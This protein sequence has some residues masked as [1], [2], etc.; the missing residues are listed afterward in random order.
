MGDPPLE[1]GAAAQT[2]LDDEGATDAARAELE[3]LVSDHEGW[4]RRCINLIASE[5]QISPAVRAQLATDLVGRYG[6]YLGRDAEHRKYFGTPYVLRIE[7]QVNDL[8]CELFGAR[9]AELRP[10]SGHVA[11]AAVLLGLCRPGDTVLEVGGDGGGHRMAAKLA[12]GTLIDLDVRFLPFDTHR[13][14]VDVAAS[15]AL[16]RE[17]R[18][19][20]VI[21]GSSTFLFPHP[22]ADL[23]DAVHSEGGLLVYDASHVMGLIA[24]GRFQQPLAEGADLIYGS[25]HK[26]LPGPQGGLI[27][28]DDERH[29]EAIT[30]ATY[31]AL[32]TNHHLARL[33]ALGIALLEVVGWG[34]AY[35]DAIIANA[36]RLAAELAGRGLPVAGAHDGYSRSHTILVGTGGHGGAEE[37]GALLEAAGMIVT[38]ARLPAHLGRVGVRLG[39]QEITRLGATEADMVELADLLFAAIARRAGP[40]ELAPRVRAWA[41]E[42]LGACRYTWGTA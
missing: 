34:H 24:A 5:N 4:R 8:A 40:D 28:A 3:G 18:P 19:R 17:A 16:I 38:A 23:A 9:Y 2:D 13:W 7:R 10:I 32:V 12:E 21:L 29:I 25:T 1:T 36:R 14:N 20:V 22:V 37:T 42:R 33:P 31:P 41:A 11:G 27:L 6:D 39:T 15:V 35:A 30:A 26:T